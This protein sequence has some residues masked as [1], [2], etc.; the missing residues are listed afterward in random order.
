MSTDKGPN[1]IYAQKHKL[2][3]YYYHFEV[4]EKIKL[5]KELSQQNS[6]KG[7]SFTNV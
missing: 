4:N 7:I 2:Y 3:Y 5:K 6:L 1:R